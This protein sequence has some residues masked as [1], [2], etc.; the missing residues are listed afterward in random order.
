MLAIDDKGLPAAEQIILARYWML[1]RVYWHHT[2]RSIMAMVKFV[3]ACLRSV[4]R[5]DIRDY[6]GATLFGGPS[7]GLAY[8]SRALA[9][10]KGAGALDDEVIDPLAELTHA[11]RRIYKRLVTAARGDAGAPGEIFERLAGRNGQA[12]LARPN[13]V[14]EEL[15]TATGERIA[16]GEV[17]IDVPLKERARTA[18]QI[19]VYLR[20]DPGRAVNIEV[21]PGRWSA[22]QR[23]RHACAQ[24]SCV[25]RS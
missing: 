2:N 17:L 10:A 12:F 25:P 8:L 16:P 18:T 20:S 23:V 6:L 13:K 7:D 9:D 24:G 21:P 5:L 14:R 22:A 3:L 11:K 1:R 15:A 4:G 19:F